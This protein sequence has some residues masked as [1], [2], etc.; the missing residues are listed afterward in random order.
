MHP[1]RFPQSLGTLLLL[2]LVSTQLLAQ[3]KTVTGTITDSLNAPL[4]GVSITVKGTEKT[5]TSNNK[6]EFSVSVPSNNAVLVFS[7]VGFATQE[8]SVGSNTTLA[9]TMKASETKMDEVVVVGYGKQSR[10]NV[11]GSVTKVDMSQTE[12]LP[13]TSFTQALRGRVAGVQ[14]IDNGRPGQGG[15]IQ[16]RG[17]RSLS[18]NSNPLIILDGVF[19]AGDY[20][21]INPNDIESMEVLKDASATAIYGTRAANGVII[22]TTKR[23]TSSKPTIRFNALAGFSG[24]SHK[25]NLY[26]PQAY[27]QRILDY[28][29]QNNQRANP[30]SI[31]FYLQTT[32]REMYEAG[33]SIDPWDVVSQDASIQS[34]DI[35]IS[36]RTDRTNYFISANYVN[37]KGLIVNDN[38]KRIVIRSNIENKITSWLTIGLNSQFT[39]RDLSGIRPP[40]ESAYW[41]SP[42]GKLYFD[43]GSLVPY[44]AVDNIEFNP[45]FAPTYYKNQALNF[46]I[47]GTTYAIINFPFLKGLSYRFNYNPRFIWDQNYTA[48]PVYN[49]AGSGYT[50][51]GLASRTNQQN[52]N[53]QYENILTYSKKLGDH[54]F[55]VT[56][57]YGRDRLAQDITRAQS[58]NLF[59][60]ALGYN[61]LNIGTTQTTAN[62]PTDAQ[63]SNSVSSMARLNYRF[64]GRYL[65][66]FTARR[67]GSSRFGE[68]KK[69]GTFP[70]AAV[71][72]VIS[73]EAFM[74]RFTYLNMLKLRLSYGKVGNIAGAPYQSLGQFVT[75]QYVFGDGSPTYTGVYSDPAYMPQP[76]LGWETTTASNVGIDF[77]FLKSRIGGTIEYYYTKTTDMLQRQSVST[78]TGFSNQYINIGQV[79][80]RGIE[81]TLNTI[82]INTKKFTWSSNIVFSAN[83]NKIVHIK[84]QD[85]NK[86]GVEDN[87][88]ANSWFIGQPINVAYDYQ[89]D[90]IYQEGDQLP[91]GYKPGWIKVKDQNKNGSISPNDD[92]VIIGQYDP[93]YRWGFTNTF[94]YQGF[95]LAV[96]INAMEG[97][98]APFDLLSVENSTG[99]G[100]FPGR[101]VNMLDAGYWTPANK[102]NTRP[103]LN[104]T[105]PLGMHFYAKRDFIRLQD[106]SLAY[107]LPK[108]IIDQ[109]R[110][111]NFRIY[112]SGRNLATRTDWPGPDPESGNRT[113]TTIYPTP[114][115]ITVGL[116]LGF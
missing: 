77:E 91:A 110:L 17:Q 51:T 16:I 53:W 25:M 93:K 105:N 60:D 27:L 5:V 59:N 103:G 109:Y 1:Q 40:M 41:L 2:L 11:T 84:N 46:S 115:T 85:A 64:K 99:G 23:G 29:A 9:V 6:G 47:F 48:Q 72:W 22:I 70:S 7:Y 37:D 101:P 113:V 92:R 67:D 83:K 30:D 71:A 79:N 19:F 75:T 87:D 63:V 28:R 55:D 112:V 3:Q 4:T 107:E 54:D 73:N 34:Y 12:N 66:T 102:S 82:N 76:D 68:N 69:Y 65:L 21:D 108:S 10:R 90:G 26:S 36:G 33:K 97:F 80:N 42:Y 78:L 81:I 114:R 100:S 49:R 98:I 52:T 86:D 104:W 18:G 14:F 74:D 35:S 88:L 24:W 89:F 8:V 57:L 116:N 62:T 58:Q 38:A 32:E 94:K 96:F 15:T 56:L 50:N 31:A 45:L 43:D 20:S 111:T 39:R 13:V 95:S 44:P 106:V 61:N